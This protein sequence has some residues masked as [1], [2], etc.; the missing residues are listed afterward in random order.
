MTSPREADL[1][2]VIAHVPRTPSEQ[3]LRAPG[4]VVQRDKD[5]GWRLAI[6]NDGRRCIGLSGA[7]HIEDLIE[8]R[9]PTLL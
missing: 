8:R 2:G 5:G 6:D 1:A 9:P 4:P 3:Q 7:D